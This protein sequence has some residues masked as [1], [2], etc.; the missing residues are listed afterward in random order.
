MA[1]S[2]INTIPYIT[3]TLRLGKNSRQH[4]SYVGE[5]PG[6]IHLPWCFIHMNVTQKTRGYK[7]LDKVHK[8][9]PA[10]WWF[11]AHEVS[12]FSGSLPNISQFPQPESWVRK[13]AE[14]PGNPTTHSN[15]KLTLLSPTALTDV[16][17]NAKDSSSPYTTACICEF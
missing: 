9:R 8:A 17:K 7:S 2:I 1:S 6:S 5:P 10:I 13:Q 4:I 15:S 14:A 16:H 12:N 11:T 3:Y